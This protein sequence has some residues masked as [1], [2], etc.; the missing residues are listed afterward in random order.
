MA[1]MA[2]GALLGFE[3]L[4]PGSK[5]LGGFIFGACLM[6]LV[7]AVMAHPAIIK[8][9]PLLVRMLPWSDPPGGEWAKGRPVLVGAQ[10]IVCELVNQRNRYLSV[11]LYYVNCTPFS[12]SVK[13]VRGPFRCVHEDIPGNVE[14]GMRPKCAGPSEKF[15]VDL[16]QHIDEAS[17]E[18]LLDGAREKPNIGKTLAGKFPNM[19]V[20]FNRIELV[21]A[22]NDNR[23]HSI[24]WEMKL[25]PSLQ[26][27]RECDYHARPLVLCT[28]D[29]EP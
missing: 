20:V 11:L 7:L 6:W 26:F 21:L 25:P 12:V 17:A 5:G 18:A 13:S 14:A 27:A 15:Q 22:G 24:E 16:V 1:L 4:F 10:L 19:E 9:Y 2:T 29:Y 8:R 23:G 28:P 3:M